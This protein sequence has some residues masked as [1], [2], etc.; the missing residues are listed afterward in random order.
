MSTP[1]EISVAVVAD[2]GQAEFW[3]MRLDSIGIGHRLAEHPEGWELLVS[4]TD[5]ARA[6]M[7]LGASARGALRSEG[8]QGQEKVEGEARPEERSWDW[9]PGVSVA[10]LLLLFFELA[11]PRSTLPGPW[12]ERGQLD[13]A[14]TFGAEPWRALTALTLHADVAHL[15]PNLLACTILIGAVC[16]ELG[17]G[18]GILLV[19]VAGTAGNG[20]TAWWEA[21]GFASVGA[22]TAVFGALGLLGVFHAMRSFQ[23]KLLL[24]ALFPLFASVMFFMRFGLG[25]Q[26]AGIA[27]HLFGLLAGVVTGAVV[28]P[29][30][31]QPPGARGQWLASGL[32]AMLIL[33]AWGLALVR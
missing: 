2:V 15:L 28:R 20:A 16:T 25:E 19:L 4:E 17:P 24:R 29:W 7:A 21:P 5:V 13:A 22:S 11:G 3:G 26:T 12:F 23:P 14:L 9:Y 10:A 32:A 33:V 1:R 6:R 31:R 8:E 30:L 27:S 18:L